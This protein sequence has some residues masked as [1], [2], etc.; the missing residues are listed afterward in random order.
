MQPHITPRII[1]TAAG[2]HFS[3]RETADPALDHVWF[4]TP[5]RRA[6]GSWA[7][8]ANACEILIRK[9][10]SRVVEG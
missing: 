10:G 2:H 4:G 8:K 7:P 1:Q 5:V 9:D 3:V 6:K